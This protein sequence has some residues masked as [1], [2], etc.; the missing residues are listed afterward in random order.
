[1]QLVLDPRFEAGVNVAR[2]NRRRQERPGRGRPGSEHD[3]Y[4]IGGFAN[5]RIIG[6]LMVGAVSNYT[7]ETDLKVN[8]AGEN[9]IRS[10]LQTFG[11]LQYVLWDDFNIKASW[12][13]RTPT[14]RPWPTRPH[15]GL[16]QQD[17]ERP[18]S[19]HVPL[20]IF[21]WRGSGSVVPSVD[22]GPRGGNHGSSHG[23]GLDMERIRMLRA[24]SLAVALFVTACSPSPEPARVATTALFDG[25]SYVENSSATAASR[26]RRRP[27]PRRSW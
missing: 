11:A 23:G 17:A 6:A 7:K 15:R 22:Q 27:P 2:A 1:V 26:W 20:L 9:D 13:T 25:T 16:S 10:H 5:A 18:A 19:L 8:A 14:L 3:I 4:S 24:A 12:P 21:R